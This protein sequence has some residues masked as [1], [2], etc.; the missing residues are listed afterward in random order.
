MARNTRARSTAASK[1]PQIP[2]P[3]ESP[4][5]TEKHPKTTSPHS[6][7]P[8]SPNGDTSPT[9]A[10]PT[11][12]G[13]A[14][15]KQK[16]KEVPPPETRDLPDRAGRNIRP[17]IPALPRAKRSH[18]E[19]E[20][21]KAAKKDKQKAENEAT[22]EKIRRLEEANAALRRGADDATTRAVTPAATR[23]RDQ[24]ATS[25]PAAQ[26]DVFQDLGKGSD[27]NEEQGENSGAGEGNPPDESG[28]DFDFK[29]VDDAASSDE[30]SEETPPPKKGAAKAKAKKGGKKATGKK[31]THSTKGKAAAVMVESD[32]LEVVTGNKGGLA[33]QYKRTLEAKQKSNSD[34]GLGGLHDSDIED[35][36]D[37]AVVAPGH[38]NLVVA[39]AA[40]AVAPAVNNDIL[41]SD[42]RDQQAAKPIVK[43]TGS[44]ARQRTGFTPRLPPSNPSSRG[45]SRTASRS[46]TPVA[47]HP[48]TPAPQGGPVVAASSE[49]AQPR[50]TRRQVESAANFPEFIKNSHG[51][52][53]KDTVVPTL[54]ACLFASRQPMSAF[55]K[56]ARFIPVIHDIISHVWPNDGP[57]YQVKVNGDSVFTQAYNRIKDIQSAIGRDARLAVDAHFNDPDFKDQP[58]K[59]VQF[60]IDAR[61]NNGP[62]WYQT[63]TPTECTAKKGEDGY[64]LK[65][66]FR[67]W[68]K[69]G[70]KGTP[71][72]DNPNFLEAKPNAKDEFGEKG[73]GEAVNLVVET[74][75]S[76]LTPEL[77]LHLMEVWGA[78]GFTPAVE[79]NSEHD[80]DEYLLDFD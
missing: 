63:P 48:Q 46:Q 75:E 70:G 52:T 67:L 56:D 31:T 9:E 15:R 1:S 66:A 72:K 27:S 17:A 77:W 73:Y 40:L 42:G 69:A 65:R 2:Q 64:I 22:A 12:R 50:R 19:V 58:A 60:C 80:P 34:E 16:K 8:T 24:H 47:S 35:N 14:G 21:E 39:V 3:S 74:Y 10:V 53:W 30:R 28:E 51:A 68:E 36:G 62:A 49:G 33:T 11:K 57:Q 26:S 43:K 13:G 7:P 79:Y 38:K 45:G 78:G 6:P 18:A 20:A 71:K 76:K 61:Q 4:P 23:V 54:R 59:I 37:H 25:P 29:A 55:P 44:Q 5:S 32:G 41:P